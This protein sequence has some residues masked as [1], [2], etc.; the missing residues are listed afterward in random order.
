MFVFV[1]FLY[2]CN[3]FVLEGFFRGKTLNVTIFDRDTM[4]RIKQEEDEHV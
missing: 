2:T 3:Y 1:L 4:L